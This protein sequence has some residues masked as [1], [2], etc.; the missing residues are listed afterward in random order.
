VPTCYSPLEIYFNGD[1]QVV[2]TYS[3]LLLG[4]N[5]KTIK[6]FMFQQQFGGLAYDLPEDN[7]EVWMWLYRLQEALYHYNPSPSME[8][9]WL[10][11]RVLE[12]LH[13]FYLQIRTQASERHRLRL[14]SH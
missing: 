9:E 6:P 11:E 4:W 12:C 13:S 3:S 2:E 14:V 8:Q 10:I 7:E 5:R 1:N